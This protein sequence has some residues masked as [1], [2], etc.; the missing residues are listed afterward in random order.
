M[1]M[2]GKHGEIEAYK[3]LAAQQDIDCSDPD[4]PMSDA[5]EAYAKELEG[6]S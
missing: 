4:D 2:L 3:R 6:D 5:L 1:E